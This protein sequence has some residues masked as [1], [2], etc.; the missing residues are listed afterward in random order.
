[1]EKPGN[2]RNYLEETSTSAD[3]IIFNLVAEVLS[4]RDALPLGVTE[5]TL[6]GYSFRGKGAEEEEEGE[7]DS[8]GRNRRNENDKREMPTII[9]A[10]N[11]KEE[12]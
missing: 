11:L 7:E 6:V 2:L 9:T 12:R 3:C 5:S 10:T 8:F 1:M 4:V